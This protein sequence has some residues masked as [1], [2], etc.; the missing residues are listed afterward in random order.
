MQEMRFIV[1]WAVVIDAAW[2]PIEGSCKTAFLNWNF[3]VL[4]TWSL[5]RNVISPLHVSVHMVNELSIWIIIVVIIWV[6]HVEQEIEFLLTILV[7]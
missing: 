4:E 7:N 6:I 2:P 3:D 1:L 5:A